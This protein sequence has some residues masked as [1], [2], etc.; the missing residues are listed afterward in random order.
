[1]KRAVQHSLL[2][3]AEA[4]QNLPSELK[5]SH[6][7]V[8]GERFMG[9]ETCSATNRRVDHEVLWSIVTEHLGTLDAAAAALSRASI[10]NSERIAARNR[11]GAVMPARGVLK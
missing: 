3:I 6:P 9:L 4:A 10:P 8:L 5:E 2:I 7:E 1:M 11:V